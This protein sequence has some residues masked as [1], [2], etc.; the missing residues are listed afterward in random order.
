MIRPYSQMHRTDEYSEDSSIILP[1]WL[2]GWVFVYELS[3]CGFESRCSHLNFRFGACL[4]QGVP[5]HSGNYRVWTQSETRSSK[6]F[7]D[8]NATIEHGFTLKRVGDII[9]TYSL[10]HRTDKYSQN[11]SIIWPVWLNDWVIV[12]ELNGCG[13]QSHYSHLNCSHFFID[14]FPIIKKQEVGSL[15][16]FISVFLLMI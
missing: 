2:N 15:R 3:G 10:M 9:R 13:F 16:D 11:K 8:I 12:Y 4:E 7:L 14:F 1:D 6:E 5:W